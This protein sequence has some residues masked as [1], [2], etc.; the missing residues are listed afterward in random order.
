MSAQ[1]HALVAGGAS[2]IAQLMHALRDDVILNLQEQR[3]SDA[4][5]SVQ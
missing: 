4:H 1:D 3:Y 5:I 2:T